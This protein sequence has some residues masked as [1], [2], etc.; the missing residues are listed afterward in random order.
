MKSPLTDQPSLQRTFAML[1]KAFF[2]VT[3][4]TL[5]SS[6]AVFLLQHGCFD[7][8]M[9]FWIPGTD[10]LAAWVYPTSVLIISFFFILYGF[11][12]GFRAIPLMLMVFGIFDVFDKLFA[13]Y[14]QGL[15]TGQ[16]G[17]GPGTVCNYA[18]SYFWIQNALMF[19][20]FVLA[21]FPKLKANRYLLVTVVVLAWSQLVWWPYLV[22]WHGIFAYQFY[23]V[24]LFVYVYHSVT[25]RPLPSWLRLRP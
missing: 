24:A 4:A 5:M 16:F 7:C 6:A 22:Q 10:I 25:L 11:R 17:C 13:L 12:F 23:E 15:V 3:G 2:V 9:V 20:G 18:D 19:G 21:G 14:F 1:Q 8:T